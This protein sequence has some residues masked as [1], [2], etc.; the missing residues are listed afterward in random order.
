MMKQT[1]LTYLY[2]FNHII[3]INWLLSSP[4]RA[5]FEP[6]L[7]LDKESRHH[8]GQDEPRPDHHA[9]GVDLAPLAPV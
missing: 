7:S 9:V 3:D 4:L 6:S 5:R 1:I 2:H 8:G